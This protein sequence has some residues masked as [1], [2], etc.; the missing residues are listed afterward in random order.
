[1]D[2]LSNLKNLVKHTSS[3][4]LLYVEDNINLQDKMKLLLDHFFNSITIASNGE[5]G[6]ELYKKSPYDIVI[7]DIRMPK[8]NGLEM[9]K[10]IL[11]IDPH[12]HIVVLSAY[13]NSEY[14]LKAIEL[15]IDGYILKPFSMDKLRLVL[16]KIVKNIILKKE[17]EN[18]QENLEREVE[19]QTLELQKQK[20]RLEM[21]FNTSKDGIAILDLETNFLDFNDAYL[22]MTGFSRAEL[23]TKSCIN[24]SVEEDIDR[25]KKVIETVLDKG[26]YENYEKGCI[27]KNNKRIT[28]N[29]S[30]AL[31]PNKKEMI[32][33]T[34]DIT[35]VKK[36]QQRVR[37]YIHLIDEN[38]ITSSTDLDGNITHVSKAFCDIC[39]YL[40]EEL[41]GVNHKI[42]MVD[43]KIYEDMYNTLISD[44]QWSGEI[45]NKHKNGNTF[46]VDV[47]I[48]TVYDDEKNKIGF[49]FINHDIT[50]KKNIEKLSITDGLTDI[51]NR[52][53]F[54]TIFPKIINSAKRDNEL[55]CFIM[56]DID[57][58]KLYNDTYGHQKGDDVL[59]NIAKTMKDSLNRIDDYSF[60]L[61]GEEFGI[62]FKT[63]SKANAVKFAN[64]FRLNIENLQI[65]HENSSVNRFVTISLGLECK[66]AKLILSK[67]ELYKEVDILLYKAK[68]TGRNKLVVC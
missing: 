66:R 13:D 67:D 54:D 58:F 7:T 18:Y 50:D 14:I 16:S 24:L 9:S 44:E 20:D 34:K 22:K 19:K 15:N 32:I 4:S 56:L 38:I 48:F 40:K 36:N 10:W 6:L 2:D 30:I 65:P 53:H 45:K 57:C 29:M 26:Y 1:M 25:S 47:S 43:E 52:R 64:K 12:Q 49:T 35:E 41:I 39:G 62:I 63:K 42:I 31:M 8:L 28:I 51:F 46:W 17:H 55:V 33:S 61:G 5:E 60:R 21:I 27:V 37:E 68:E 59:I 23:L 3:L 11:A